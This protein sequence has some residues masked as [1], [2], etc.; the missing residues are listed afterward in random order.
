MNKRVALNYFMIVIL[1]II[2]LL[3]V[4]WTPKP[5]IAWL[6]HPQTVKIVEGMLE[7]YDFY[8]TLPTPTFKKEHIELRVEIGL[9]SDGVMVWRKSK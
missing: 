6:G 1:A 4:A 5:R 7:D 2:W 9:R 3:I 8:D